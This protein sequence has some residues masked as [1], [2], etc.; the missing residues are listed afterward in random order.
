MTDVLAEMLAVPDAYIPGLVDTGT[1]RE[2][3]ITHWHLAEWKSVV[4]NNRRFDQENVGPHIARG[5]ACR[6]PHAALRWAVLT[7][8]GIYMSHRDPVAAFA[9]RSWRTPADVI[10]SIDHSWWWMT[11]Q[12]SLLVPIG[13]MVALAADGWTAHVHAHPMTQS[14]CRQH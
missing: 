2:I 4:S 6:D 14:H 5:E 11:T 13:G 1:W 3:G 9:Q 12:P 7:P 8:M 10:D